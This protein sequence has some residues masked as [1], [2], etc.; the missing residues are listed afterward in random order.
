[1]SAACCTLAI[2]PLVRELI[3]YLAGQEPLYPAQGK[4]ARLAAV[5]LEQIP[6]AARRRY[7]DHEVLMYEGDRLRIA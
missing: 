1:M 4:M 5:L 3:L 2:T 6:D 7:I